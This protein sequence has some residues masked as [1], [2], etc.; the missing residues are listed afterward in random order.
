[1]HPGRL[2]CSSLAYDEYAALVAPCQPGAS[3]LGL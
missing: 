3:A 1:M 2:R